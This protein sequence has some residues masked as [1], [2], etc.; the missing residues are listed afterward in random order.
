LCSHNWQLFLPQNYRMTK[1]TVFCC[2][3][4]VAMRLNAQQA[5]VNCYVPDPDAAIR[6]HNVDFTRLNLNISFTPEDGALSG[7]ADYTFFAIQPS[8]DSVFLDGPGILVQEIMLDNAKTR[9]KIDSAGIT[10]FFNPPLKRNVEHRLKITYDATPKRGIYFVGWNYKNTDKTNDPTVIR[11][12]IWTQGQGIDNRHWIPS[13]DGLND[14]L[15]TSL[16]VTFDKAYTVVS[17]G[18]LKNAPTENNGK[19]TWQYEMPHPHALY[20][21]MLAIGQ[22]EYMDYTSKNGMV[23]RQYYYPGTKNIAEQTYMYSAEMM[24][25]LVEETGTPYPWTTYANVPV[26]EFLYGAMENTTATIFS[27]FF[28]QDARTFPDKNYVEI[29]AHELTHQW[30]GDYIAAWSGSSH[31]L[32][33]SFATYYAKKFRQRISGEDYYHW[34]RR[35]EMNT[36]FDADSKNDVPVGHSGAG[37]PRVYQKGSIVLDMLRYVVGD[38]QFKI[39]IHDFLARYPYQNVE[40]NDFE[41]QF[42]RSMGINVEWF[43]DEWIYRGGFPVYNVTYEK[44]NAATIVTVMQQQKQN[45][46]VKLFKMP[47]HIQVHY[48]DGSFDDQLV[49]IENASATVTFNNTAAKEVAFVLFDPNSMVYAKVDFAK[50]YTELKYQA[51]NAINMMDRYDA[52]VMMR[53]TPIE[54]KRDDL[55][56]LFK[57]ETFHGIKSEIISQLSNDDNKASI[58]LLKIALKDAHPYVRRAVVLNLKSVP[59]GLEK[60]LTAMLTDSNYTN[61]E[62][63]LTKLSKLEPGNTKKYLTLTDNQKGST[64]NIR[65]SWLELANKEYNNQYINELVAF[66]SGNYEFRTRNAAFVA[67]V[68]LNYCDAAVVENLYNALISGNHRLSNPARNALTKLKETPAYNQMIKDYYKS[69]TWSEWE[70]KR[71][72]TIKE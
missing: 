18:A 21:V 46:T 55:I 23:S 22:Y 31:W 7:I 42:M 30:F 50:D 45:E 56:A 44:T 41:M 64:N 16:T 58:A 25:F 26:Q 40:S 66:S 47:V 9:F 28:Y 60:E 12:Q 37:S 4:L 29:N 72:G 8:V 43:F 67:I 6:E 32:Q 10:V 63:A 49:W 65:I 54:K 35:E 33:E 1:F 2:C 48:L 68:N 34:K 69:H 36:A 71:I 3:V 52:V 62:I 5:E 24:D 19:K 38:E 27:D 20:L 13:Y 61:V 17:N 11:K 51:F 59:K 57:K 39:A 15:I 53:E 70:Q 14:K